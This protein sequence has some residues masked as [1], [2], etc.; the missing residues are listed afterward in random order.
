MELPWL[1][2]QRDGISELRLAPRLFLLPKTLTRIGK[3][4]NAQQILGY[5]YR[6]WA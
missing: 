1:L 4:I 2:L 3:A 6:S 5:F